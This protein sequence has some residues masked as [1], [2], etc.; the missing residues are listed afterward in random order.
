METVV[1]QN[2]DVGKIDKH[3][4]NRNGCASRQTKGPKQ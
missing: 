2:A 3:I 4:K 1:D